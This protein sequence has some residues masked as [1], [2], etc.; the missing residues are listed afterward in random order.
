MYEYPKVGSLK[1]VENGKSIAELSASIREGALSPVSIDAPSFK[2]LVE[3]FTLAVDDVPTL[4]SLDTVAISDAI[5]SIYRV[6]QSSKDIQIIRVCLRALLRS[7]RFSRVLAARF[8]HGKSISMRNL[9]GILTNMGADDRLALAHEMLLDYPGEHDKQ[10]MNWLESLMTPL[11]ATEPEELAPFIIALGKQ[12]ETLAFPARQIIT[13]GLFGPWLGT[14]L[15]TGASGQDLE[16]ICHIVVALNDPERAATLA[17]T[18]SVGFITPTPLALRTVARVAEA[19]TKPIL[20][21]LLMTLKASGKKLAGEC[22]DGI[23]A[24]QSPAAGKLLATIRMKMPSLRKAAAVRVPLL[25]DQGYVSYLSALP[26][27]QRGKAESEAFAALLAM[28]P[29]FVES[30]TRTGVGM[31]MQASQDDGGAEAAQSDNSRDNCPKPGFFARLFGSRPKTLEKLLPTIRN[32]REMDLNCSR[33]E[34]EEL[35]GRELSNLILTNSEFLDVSFIRTNITS[36]TFPG[37]TF[38]GGSATGSTFSK[39]NFSGVDFTGMKFTNCTFVDCNFTNGAFSNCQF[40]ECRFRNCAM[41]GLAFLNVTMRLSG[42]TT[43]ILAGAHF[44]ETTIRS[45]RFEDVDLSMANMT[46]ATVAGS[47]FINSIFNGT[48]IHSSS[49]H[50]SDMPGTS[51]THCQITNSDVGH[52]LFLGN[53][54]RQYTNTAKAMENEPLPNPKVVPPEVARKVLLTWAREHA[55]LKRE[56]RMLAYNRT[57]LARAINSMERDKQV[58]LRILPHML[59]TDVF[60][61]KFALKNVPSCDVWGYTSSLSAIELSKQFFP[62]HKPTRGKADVHILAVYAMGSLGTVAQTATSDLD[63]W[64]CYEGEIGSQAMSGLKQKLDALGLWAESEFG[65]EAH[66]F[67]MSMDDVRD[68]I[69]SS[70]D[71]ESSGSAQALLLKEEFYRTA[72]RIAGKHLAWWVTPASANRKAYDACI[73]SARRY[74]LTGRPRLEDFGHLAPVPADEYF[75][76]SLWQMVKAVHSPFKSVLKLGLL[77]SYADPKTSP[78]PLCNR[79]KH[80]IFMNRHGVRRTDPYASLF[81]TLRAYYAEGGDDEAAQLL[82]ESFMFKANLCDIPFFMNLPARADDASLIETLFGEGY[83]D[84]EQVCNSDE[85]WTFEKS[86]KMGASVRH[87]MVNTYQH[88][89]AVLTQGGQTD[90]LINSADLTRMGRRIAA[91]F[92]KKPNKIMR[93]P[94]MDTKSDGF[95]ILHLSA[96]KAPGKK[97]VWVT[98]GGSKKE[99]K[100]SAESL[101][102]LHR[103]GDI[104][105]M[106]AWLLANQIYTPKSLLQADRTIAPISVADLQ[107]LM[108]AMHEF[109]PF[110]DTF[111]RDI[112]E[113]LDAERVVRVYFLFNM[114]SPAEAK[115]IEQ[116]SVIYTTN[117]GEMYCRTFLKPDQQLA[118]HASEFLRKH[119]DHPVPKTPEML[120]FL[121]KGSQCKR[122]NLI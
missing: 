81:S 23:I 48:T 114:T 20:D 7:G 50:A 111:E 28:A 100:K 57:R 89:Q 5:L 21:M 90:T 115:V 104:A 13:N 75:G 71:E 86:L 66:F 1:M 112:N 94:F 18:I 110:M 98:R 92:S 56:E 53:I 12:G 88:I 62:E 17:A 35:D 51:V 52:A 29:D 78:L 46:N 36:T 54:V 10:T 70:G 30:L 16:D 91:N 116:A 58:F 59:D 11:A 121:P 8:V 95:T 49:F 80:N 68:N 39:N 9:A 6:I 74:P 41:N 84:P 14:R 43:S 76:A 87:Y 117:W 85:A 63:C 106:L 40:S 77:E 26:K 73:Q 108:P 82:T 47:E 2:A 109:F 72:L 15:E 79:I 45:C 65:L 37:A 22:L 118:E 64:V 119:L 42:I 55:L 31:D 101:Q 25:G 32:I 83:T 61:R 105:H 3:A 97:P 67:P 99:A 24:Q 33:V 60:E 4:P 120:Q 93:V 103:S 34:S 27:D 19:G 107:K 69:F 113:G 96:E 44:F 122:I 102:L 38:T